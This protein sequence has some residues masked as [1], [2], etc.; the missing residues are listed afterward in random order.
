MGQMPKP[1]I[2]STEPG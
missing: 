1:T 2:K